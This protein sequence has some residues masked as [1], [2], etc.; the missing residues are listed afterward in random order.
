MTEADDRADECFRFRTLPEAG[1]EAA[2]DLELMDRQ[3]A[4]VREARIAGSEVVE[5]DTYPRF[6]ERGECGDCVLGIG[7]QEALGDLERERA[8]GNRRE[9]L[10][11]PGHEVRLRELASRHVDGD[12]EVGVVMQPAQRVLEHAPAQRDDQSRVL[13]ERDEVAGR[14]EPELGMVPAHERFERHRRP[15]ANVDDRLVVDDQLVAFQRSV[16]TRDARQAVCSVRH[17][18]VGLELDAAAPTLLGPVHRVVGF[19]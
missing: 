11:E 9:K 4:Q 13:G 7:D 6:V 1:H 10:G 17:L 16:Q 15:G 18:A 2:V 3:R 19:A 8:S 5:R 14:D 12:R